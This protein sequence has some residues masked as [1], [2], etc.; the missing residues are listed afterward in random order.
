[1]YIHTFK[2][3]S[4]HL[5]CSCPPYF[6]HP[7]HTH[8][9]PPP[10]LSLHHIPVFHYSPHSFIPLYHMFFI[11]IFLFK[12][13]KHTHPMHIFFIRISPC[14]FIHHLTS[15]PFHH[16]PCLYPSCSPKTTHIHLIP[17]LHAYMSYPICIAIPHLPIF[18]FT[19]FSLS[20]PHTLH[21]LFSLS[22]PSP[23]HQSHA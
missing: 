23:C 14:M 5:S 18:P 3:S 1:M 19:T 2:P 11:P 13:I 20:T 17:S 7:M 9:M 4:S 16:T 21:V 10:F 6:I 12:S 8:F 22:T 15:S